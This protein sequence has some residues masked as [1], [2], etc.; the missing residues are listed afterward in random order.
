M[1]VE[2]KA[3]ELTLPTTFHRLIKELDANYLL[4]FSC[5]FFMKE[6]RKENRILKELYYYNFLVVCDSS[7][8]FFLSH[9]SI[10]K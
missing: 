10:E 3:S 7:I 4:F 2:C 6:Y 1:G 9:L 8:T 5:K